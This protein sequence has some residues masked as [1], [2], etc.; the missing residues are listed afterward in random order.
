MSQIRI[1]DQSGDKK[2]F[3]IIPNYILNHSTLYDREVYIQMKRIAGEN[4][5]C[6]MSQTN[7]AKQCGISVNRL[8]KS[9]KYL[10]EHEWIKYV[11]DKQ[12]TS[13]GGEQSTKEYVI[14]DLWQKNAN[15]YDKGVSRN[16]TPRHKGVSPDDRGG[17]HEMT[18]GVSPDAYKEEPFKKNHIK[19]NNSEPSSQDDVNKIFDIFY[20]TINPTINYGNTTSRKATQWMIDKWGVD[21]VVAMTEYACSIHGKPYAPTVTTPYQLKEKLSSIKAYKEKQST[22]N[23]VIAE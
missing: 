10:L 16:D 18:K 5:T 13:R 19:K 4:G 2:Y 7:L 1:D 11:G 22:N 20:N 6:W 8:K 12:S 17:Y 21:A 15:H 23:L 14:V 9:L 3:T